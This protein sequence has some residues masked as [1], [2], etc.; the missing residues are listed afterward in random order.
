MKCRIRKQVR[1]FFTGL[2][3]SVRLSCGFMC[4]FLRGM[5]PVLCVPG[6]HLDSR[7]QIGRYC[8]TDQFLEGK[9]WKYLDES[10][11]DCANCRALCRRDNDCTGYECGRKT[12]VGWLKGMCGMS[13]S[14]AG[15][16]F[17]PVYTCRMEGEMQSAP[18]GW[19]R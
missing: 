7:C 14:D 13:T 5:S 2:C 17:G 18:N 15:V 6:P 11:G 19:K 4:S 3:Y 9:D 1:L 8:P 16:L 10:Y 12:C